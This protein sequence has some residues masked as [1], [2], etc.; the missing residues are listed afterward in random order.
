MGDNID[1]GVKSRYMRSG[2]YRGQSLHYLH[3]FAV[4]SRIDFSSFPDTHPDTCLDSPERRAKFLLPSI[5]DDSDLKHGISV[6]I[7]RILAKNMP[8]FWHTFEDVVQWHIKHKYYKEMSSKSVV[9]SICER[10][11]INTLILWFCFVKYLGT[12][13][14]CAKK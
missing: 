7:S 14:N 8:F 10:I 11:V 13:G 12:I 1:K 4:Q 5:E 2:K 6:L 9:V 3:S